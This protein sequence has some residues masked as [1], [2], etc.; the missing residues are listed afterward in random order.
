M[1]D[2]RARD[3]QGVRLVSWNILAAPWASPQ[4]YPKEMDPAVLDRRARRV[5]V[6]RALEALGPD[7]CCVQEATPPDLE[8]IRCTLGDH[9]AMHFA[10]NGE[11]LWTAWASPEI[12]WEPNGTAVAWDTRRFDCTARG[13]IDLGAHGNVATWARLLDRVSAL[14]LIAISVHLDSDDRDRRRA[15]IPPLFATIDEVARDEMPVLIAGDYN[16]DT[17]APDGASDSAACGTD[18]FGTEFF[19][20][21]FD[22]ALARLGRREPTHAYARPGDD[23]AA[24]ATIDHVMVRGLTPL[25][26]RVVDARLWEIESAATRMEECLRRTGSDHLAVCVDLDAAAR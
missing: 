11:A 1:T 3:E 16:E 5:E 9:W 18:G 12:A 10:S 2:P 15:E 14:A 22:D 17:I 25:G 4:W 19:A 6:A 21:G 26:G 23:W 24:L 8:A 13:A 20:R 7:L